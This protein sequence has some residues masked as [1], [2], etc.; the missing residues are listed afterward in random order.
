MNKILE[1]NTKN[2]NKI[3]DEYIETCISSKEILKWGAFITNK[4]L[5]LSPAD[6]NLDTNKYNDFELFNNLFDKYKAQKISLYELKNS[7]NDRISSL[8]YY[9]NER[10]YNVSSIMSSLKHMVGKIYTYDIFIEEIRET[11]DFCIGIF[12]WPEDTSDSIL[13]ELDNGI[14]IRDIYNNQENL[15]INFTTKIIYTDSPSKSLIE[16]TKISL[17]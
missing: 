17:H 9:F 6:K 11:I 15:D 3:I 13:S 10:E 12:E 7:I 16:V 1:I 4:K 8:L 14:C 2:Y 5:Y